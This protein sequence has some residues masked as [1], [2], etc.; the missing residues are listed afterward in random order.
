MPTY[1]SIIGRSDDAAALIPEDVSRDIWK[2]ATQKS[3]ALMLFQRR[4]MSRAQQRLP[5][6][7]LKPSAYFVTGDT[8][9]KQTGEVNW[10][11]KY[12]DAE[13]IAVIVPISKNL[14]SDVDYDIWA[15][16][17]PEIEEAIAAVID[18]AIFFGVNKPA[19]WPSDIKTASI[20]AGNTVT[21]GTS[22]IDF[23]DDFNQVRKLVVKDGYPVNGYLMRSPFR[24]DL[25]NVRDTTK[26]F[27]FT[28]SSFQ[29]LAPT[30]D[31][32]G[33]SAVTVGNIL[34]HK[35]VV[36]EIGLTGFA[37]LSLNAEAFVGDF[38]QG[39]IGIRQDMEFETFREGVI[40][41]GNGAIV[42]NLLQQDMIAMRVTIRLGWQVPN[43]VN[44]VQTVTANR[45]PFGVLRQA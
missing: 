19:S 35:A 5:V 38:R 30:G 33:P 18:D 4:R 8:G 42:Y 12:I 41:D 14:L 34:G 20:A 15:E 9:L 24:E 10:A 13:E 21:R 27:L 23:V 43:P 45:Y 36:S 29:S 22:T 44:R 16:I 2:A 6:L 26:Q 11:N 31:N 1:N 39:I 25:V 40:Q 37:D 17:K 28:S 7:S 3:A 32:S